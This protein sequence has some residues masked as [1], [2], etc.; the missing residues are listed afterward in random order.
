MF[1]MSAGSLEGEYDLPATAD[2]ILTPDFRILISGPAKVNVSI[3]ARANGDA[4][5]RSRGEESYVV[6]SELMG[7]DFY[8]VQPNEQVIFHPG[9]VKKPDL[10]AAANCGC[11]APPVVQIAEAPTVPP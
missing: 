10:D 3:T 7:D 1:A 6:I 11:P 5:I 8:R 2:A 4:C 9:N